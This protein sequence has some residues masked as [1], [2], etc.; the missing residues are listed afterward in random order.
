MFKT[1]LMA[2]VVAI[3][4]TGSIN[5]SIVRAQDANLSPDDLA[6]LV[7]DSDGFFAAIGAGSVPSDKLLDAWQAE[8]RRLD[9]IAAAIEK[10]PPVVLHAKIYRRLGV[11][12]VFLSA[13]KGSQAA[14]GWF[15]RAEEVLDG[16][17]PVQELDEKLATIWKERA[18]NLVLLG[19]EDRARFY[20]EKALRAARA[21]SYKDKLGEATIRERLA[22]VCFRKELWKETLDIIGPAVAIM[23]PMKGQPGFNKEALRMPLWYQAIA[24][25]RLKQDAEPLFDRYLREFQN[26]LSIHDHADVYREAAVNVGERTPREAGPERTAGLRK[27]HSYITRAEQIISES[28]DDRDAPEKVAIL[29]DLAMSY[30]R[31]GM[32]DE[33]LKSFEAAIAVARQSP[34]LGKDWTGLIPVLQRYAA[35]LD[36]MEQ[37]EPGKGHHE[38]AE[39][40]RTEARRIERLHQ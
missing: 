11:A 21:S 28:K 40:Q 16:A 8:R 34:S 25:A 7:R 38:K 31:G 15:K 37:R 20:L 26:D 4:M 14:D 39:S 6:N 17:G 24:T 13:G 27:A 3:T 30:A 33:S 32:G 36:G 35:V 9:S 1:R 23:T 10:A 5:G 29:A 18:D 19:A 2:I 22:G 12:N